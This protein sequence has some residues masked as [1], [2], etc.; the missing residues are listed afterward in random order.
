MRAGMEPGGFELLAHLSKREARV[1][2][3]RDASA[4]DHA[5][6]VEHAEADPFHV[7]RA[8]RDAQRGAFLEETVARRARW[9]RRDARNQR[10]EAF[11][12]CSSRIGSCHKDVVT[13]W[14]EDGNLIQMMRQ[15][16]KV[17][18]ENPS[19]PIVCVDLNGVLD[20]YTGWKHADH[21]DPPRT[22][23]DA[24]LKGLTERGFDVVIFTTRHH[25]QVRRW[26]RDHGL[27]PYVSAITRR[28]PPAHVF[29]DDRAVCFRGNFDET[30]ERVAAFKA[31]WET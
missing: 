15:A 21:W 2:G 11:F 29:V 8:N 23:A 30:L 12:G 5:I 6:D 7:E 10:F 1:V 13:R 3:K 4:I 28:K 20:S 16:R 19:L 24:F 14:H 25:T 27:L 22:G 31:H 18:L 17:D 9:L 26:L